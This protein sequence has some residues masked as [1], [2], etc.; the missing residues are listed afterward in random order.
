[1]RLAVENTT[2]EAQLSALVGA[3]STGIVRS[4]KGLLLLSEKGCKYFC[5]TLVCC[6]GTN[7]ERCGHVLFAII[8]ASHFC[9]SYD[10]K[11]LFE[12]L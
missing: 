2:M 10:C 1:M 8:G 11:F 12:Y 9:K 5:P 4:A 6:T 3:T 7:L